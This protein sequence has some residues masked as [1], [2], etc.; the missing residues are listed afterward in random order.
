MRQILTTQGKHVNKS[1]AF[2]KS[3]GRAI[4]Q[5]VHTFIILLLIS[6]VWLNC[7]ERGRMLEMMN[8]RF[9]IIIG[10]A[11]AIASK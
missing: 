2:V 5:Q 10:V 1:H 9:F 4:P 11:K 3:L 6:V 7:A 8:R